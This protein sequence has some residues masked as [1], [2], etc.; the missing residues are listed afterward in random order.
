[1][2]S[3]SWIHISIK[4]HG[5]VTGRRMM[6]TTAAASRACSAWTSRTCIQIITDCPAGP[7]LWPETSSKPGPRKNTTRDR[8]EGRTRGRW[9]GPVRRGRS[10]GYGPGRWAAPRS[11]CSERPC[12][13]FSSTLS[14]TGAQGERRSPA[15]M[16][17][18]PPILGC[19]PG[20]AERLFCAPGEGAE[21]GSA[22]VLLAPSIAKTGLWSPALCREGTVSLGQRHCRSQ[23]GRP[24]SGPRSHRQAGAG[25]WV[26]YLA[27]RR[28]ADQWHRGRPPRPGSASS[29]CDHDIGGAGGP[30]CGD[31]EPAGDLRRGWP[32]PG[33]PVADRPP[34]PVSV[35]GPVSSATAPA[36][37]AAVST[38][39]APP[40][41]GRD[42][43]VSIPSAHVLHR[44]CTRGR[45]GAA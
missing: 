29:I 7:G 32:A 34:E 33:K 24:G 38:P 37:A 25:S 20:G 17:A 3:G 27:R 4:P 21:R 43:P 16:R 22:E 35:A 12:G 39:P 36:P 40:Q 23:P 9:P 41:A 10:G 8:P 31:D 5:S 11:G 2:P 6:G 28:D 44:S 42:R 15:V 19:G 45:C 14:D 18:S 30:V 13:Y 26:E 1:M